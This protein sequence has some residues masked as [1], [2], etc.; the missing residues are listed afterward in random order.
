MHTAG[1]NQVKHFRQIF[2]ASRPLSHRGPWPRGRRGGCNR[3][4]ACHNAA[5]NNLP[6]H[7]FTRHGTICQMTD[8]LQ[9]DAQSCM[10]LALCQAALAADAGEVPVGAVAV[11]DGRILARAHNQVEMLKDA[12]AH[13]EM[14]CLTQA[15]AALGDWRLG[16]VTL[17]VTKEPCAMCAGAIDRKSTRLNSSHYS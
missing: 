9:R 4:A 10:R 1:A 8:I 11:A 5:R 7:A 6:P 14:L 15:A 16:A 17:Y 3:P 2:F 12:T 13:A